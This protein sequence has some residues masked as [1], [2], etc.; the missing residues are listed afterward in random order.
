MKP[1]T[2]LETVKALHTLIWGFFVA[3]IVGAPLAAWQGQL[4]WAALLV[5]CVAL[6]GLVLLVNRWSCPL[7]GV[8]ARYT[9]RRDENF[10]IYLPR[11]LAKHN[12]RI[13]TPLYVLGT[14]Y[15]LYVWLD[16]A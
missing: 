9:D 3:C 8:A 16:R 7:T 6:E 12:K 15:V 1:H 2:A 11:W 14:G 4:G 5:G 10:D 13:F